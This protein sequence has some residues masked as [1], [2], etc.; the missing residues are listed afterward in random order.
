MINQYRQTSPNRK[1]S[2]NKSMKNKDS[3]IKISQN[4]SLVTYTQMK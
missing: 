3:V 1:K 4:M 2:E